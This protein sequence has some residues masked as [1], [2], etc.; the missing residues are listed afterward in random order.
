MTEQKAAFRPDIQALRFIAVVSVVL[1]HA[2]LPFISGGFIG[3]DIFFVISGYLIIGMLHREFKHTRKIN[4]IEFWARRMRRLMPA[5]TLVITITLLLTF[6]ISGPF[7]AKGSAADA[8][9]AS[10]YGANIRFALT[11]SDYF[12][13]IDQSPF[14][15][16]WSLGVEEQFYF[17]LPILIV[18]CAKFFRISNIFK[19]FV[20][21]LV[22]AATFSI[23]AMFYFKLQ[24]SSWEFYGPLSRGWEFAAGGIAA[25]LN[26]NRRETQVETYKKRVLY[27]A[28]VALSWVTIIL[29][30]FLISFQDV[31]ANLK[32]AVPVF[33]AAVLLYMNPTL[34]S[35][36]HLENQVLSNRFV[37]KIGNYSYSLYL[38]HWPVLIFGFSILEIN[39]SELTSL[40]YLQITALIAISISLAFLTWKYV[41]EP[42]RR[43]KTLISKPN[44]SLVLGVALSVSSFTMALLVSQNSFIKLSNAPVVAV[45]SA[46]ETKSLNSYEIDNLIDTFAPKISSA[47]EY[48]QSAL[49]IIKQSQAVKNESEVDGCFVSRLKK[50]DPNDACLYGSRSGE[51]WV[52]FGDSFANMWMPGLTPKGDADTYGLELQTRGVCTP[53][54]I[55]IYDAKIAGRSIECEKWRDEVIN[56]LVVNPPDVI[57]VGSSWISNYT[58]ADSSGG[59]EANKEVAQAS[60]E[61]GLSALFS[62]LPKESL[63]IYI[64]ATPRMS[65]DVPNCL[66]TRVPKACQ[67]PTADALDPTSAD[68]EI[69]SRFPS[70]KLLDLTQALCS[71]TI[72]YS[73]RGGSMVYRDSGHVTADYSSKLH[74]MFKEVVK[75][76]Q[77]NSMNEN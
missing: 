43:N 72:C 14:L 25:V 59:A 29:S 33:A 77:T 38:W 41:E 46:P 24:T 34:R 37:Q 55:P 21:L 10:F 39:E 11:E 58:V 6:L 50:V 16:F 2:E 69:A 36:S 7:V 17:G 23:A 51:R 44:L 57:I 52:L 18:L 1:F 48:A 19:F 12:S 73:V 64:R 53:A 15:H 65:F 75:A 68:V 49:Q 31:N 42:I 35:S 28:I 5:A 66:S 26:Q 20:L 8:M 9:W 4:V 67:M 22:G 32:I 62:K 76:L 56:R 45:S 27:T 40:S 71:E 74:V 70:V 54:L 3:V 63:I 30:C 13:A 47:D 61:F 60:R